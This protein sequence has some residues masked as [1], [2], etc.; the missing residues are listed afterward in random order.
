[1]GGFSWAGYNV[2]MRWFMTLLVLLCGCQSTAVRVV[3]ETTGLPVA[4]AKVEHGY[5][6]DPSLFAILISPATRKYIAIETVAT[7]VDGRAVVS[8]VRTGHYLFVTKP[9]YHR[10]E[11]Y[12]DLS[13]WRFLAARPELRDGELVLPLDRTLP[14]TVPVLPFP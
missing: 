13:G 6:K 12:N 1:M 14:G 5:A 9:A 4:G 7:D 10:L 2:S 8:D 3:D 11:V